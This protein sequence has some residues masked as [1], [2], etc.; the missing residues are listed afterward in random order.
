MALALNNNTIRLTVFA[1]RFLIRNMQL[2]GAKPRLVR[3]PFVV[4]GLGPGAGSGLLAFAGTLGTLTWFQAQLGTMTLPW[5]GLLAAV[6]VDTGGVLGR[7]IQQRGCEPLP[8]RRPVSTSLMHRSL[9]RRA[10]FRPM[11][12]SDTPNNPSNF[13]FGRSNYV[14]LGVGIATLI[15]GYA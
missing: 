3:R 14:W 2:V 13:A 12:A 15:L 1:R 7:R 11:N 10:V 8:A 4:Q 5:M 9:P 6:F